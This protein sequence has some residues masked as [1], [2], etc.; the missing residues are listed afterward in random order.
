MSCH[1]TQFLLKYD[2]TQDGGKIDF[3]AYLSRQYGV[4]GD[5]KFFLATKW[6]DRSWLLW[7]EGSL[8]LLDLFCCILTENISKNLE[9][10]I[11]LV[12]ELNLCTYC[13]WHYIFGIDRFNYLHPRYYRLFLSWCKALKNGI[14]FHPLLKSWWN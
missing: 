1:I 14:F 9:I 5:S 10:N 13:S 3:P 7:I 8:F 12:Q 4:T 2:D 6:R 11:I